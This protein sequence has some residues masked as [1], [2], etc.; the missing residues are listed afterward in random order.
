[1][2][3]P[4]I[5]SIYLRFLFAMMSVQ[6]P[7]VFYRESNEVLQRGCNYKRSDFSFDSTR[8]SYER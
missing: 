8:H 4:S 3:R 1:M 5:F 6:S 2:D 7:S